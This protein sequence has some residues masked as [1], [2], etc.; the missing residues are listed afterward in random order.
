VKLLLAI[1]LKFVT[2]MLKSGAFGLVPVMCVDLTDVP[3]SP[4]DA[5]ASPSPGLLTPRLPA[6]VPIRLKILA[7]Y[8]DNYRSQLIQRTANSFT[9]TIE[10]VSINHRRFHILVSQ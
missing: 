4:K 9:T 10:N 3:M 5:S 6:Q 7:G 8:V 1:A 2:L